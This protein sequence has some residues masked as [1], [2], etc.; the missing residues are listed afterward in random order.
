MPEDK[1][2]DIFKYSIIGVIGILL[3]SVIYLF[4]NLFVPCSS[5]FDEPT[6]E[7][8]PDRCKQQ[9]LDNKTT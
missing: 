9:Y 2:K 5:Y 7:N 8:V 6:I 3:S 1:K 4:F